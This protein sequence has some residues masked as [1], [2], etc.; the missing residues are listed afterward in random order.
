[1]AVLAGLLSRAVW[2]PD[3]L[4]V[5][6]GLTLGVAASA[7]VVVLA[8]SLTRPLG[9]AA[10]GGWLLGLVALLSGR[11][12]GDYVIASDSL[13]LAYLGLATS[14]VLAAAL[15]PAVSR[16]RFGYESGGRR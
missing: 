7:A 12:E 1:M 2:R 6:W 3:N 13:G 15:W 8:R 16:S 14:A 5:P 10:A 4:S 9:F 11:R